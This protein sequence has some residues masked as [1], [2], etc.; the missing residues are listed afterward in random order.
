M[1]HIWLE[2]NKLEPLKVAIEN[3]PADGFLRRFVD[4]SCLLLERGQ[5]FLLKCIHGALARQAFKIGLNPARHGRR[6]YVSDHLCA[7]ADSAWLAG[8]VPDWH[9]KLPIDFFP[10]IDSAVT[11]TTKPVTGAAYAMAMAAL[12]GT[13]TEAM[14]YVGLAEETFEMHPGT[15][16]WTDKT[17]EQSYYFQE[18]IKPIAERLNRSY[19]HSA[20]A[21][22]LLGLPNTHE[23][24][25]SD[26]WAVLIRFLYGESIR[27]ACLAEQVDKND[28]RALLRK[29]SGNVMP[30]LKYLRREFLLRL[31]PSTNRRELV[32]I[33]LS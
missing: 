3:L 26:A 30:T 10:W 27:A 1:P 17:D 18:A 29:C 21:F 8:H 13:S 33:K 31:A 4:I 7:Q 22:E 16:Y 25:P 32:Y 12:Y 23:R 6:P 9:L 24:R 20:R 19:Y 5:P 15:A 28:V 11:V 14:Q 2:K